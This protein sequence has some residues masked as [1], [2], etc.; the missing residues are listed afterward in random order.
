M[1]KAARYA[2]DS[3]PSELAPASRLCF[4]NSLFS[5]AFSLV[6][7]FRE[8]PVELLVERRVGLACH[9]PDCTWILQKKSNSYQITRLFQHP[10]SHNNG[11]SGNSINRTKSQNN[12]LFDAVSVRS[13]PLI[14]EH[15]C[16]TCSHPPRFGLTSPQALHAVQEL[17]TR[18]RA[19]IPPI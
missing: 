4:L 7:E 11:R 3:P 10:A 1:A 18:F 17:D 5:T 9:E 19:V 16:R 15:P 13:A 2:R 6:R 8:L 14:H 12:F